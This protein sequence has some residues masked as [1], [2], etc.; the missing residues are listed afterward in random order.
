MEFYQYTAGFP[1][2]NFVNENDDFTIP[3]LVFFHKLAHYHFFHINNNQHTE[4]TSFISF[5][6]YTLKNADGYPIRN[7]FCSV[8]PFP[9][10]SRWGAAPAICYRI[11]VTTFDYVSLWVSVIVWVSSLEIFAYSVVNPCHW[12]LIFIIYFHKN[13][14]YH[15]NQLIS[16]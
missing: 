10:I 14:R 5:C 6:S 9:L 3:F 16:E 13:Y 15:Q 11:Y 4:T 7:F 8:Y 12:R 1:W 2:I